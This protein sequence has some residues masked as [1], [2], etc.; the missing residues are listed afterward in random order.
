MKKEELSQ[1]LDCPDCDKKS[2]LKSEFTK[3]G[4]VDC[5]VLYYKCECGAEFTT[6]DSEDTISMDNYDSAKNI[7]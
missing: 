2:V 4:G 7:F 1:E 3:I 6:T 5:E